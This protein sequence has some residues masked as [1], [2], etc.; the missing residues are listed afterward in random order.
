MQS[1]M[2]SVVLSHILA[3]AN[4]DFTT[5]DFLSAWMYQPKP[6]HFYLPGYPVLLH[7]LAARGHERRQKQNS[8]RGLVYQKIQASFWMPLQNLML[9]VLISAIPVVCLLPISARLRMVIKW[10]I[11]MVTNMS[12]MLP[13]SI[14]CLKR[15]MLKPRHSM[16][17]V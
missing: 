1:A 16:P 8:A 6:T 5:V 15:N 3:G 14:S 10:L 7:S 17:C 11:T 2:H 13:V 4:V 9:S 12:H